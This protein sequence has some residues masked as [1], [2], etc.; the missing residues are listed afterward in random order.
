MNTEWNGIPQVFFFFL[1]FFPLPQKQH[2][3]ATVFS[4]CVGDNIVV[5]YLFNL[6][7][8]CKI[9]VEGYSIWKFLCVAYL[10]ILSWQKQTISGPNK[11]FFLSHCLASSGY[12]VYVMN[13]IFNTSTPYFLPLKSCHA[14]LWLVLAGIMI[15]GN[16]GFRLK[17]KN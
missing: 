14:H 11:S 6:V 9:T 5:V 8:N 1:S 17:Q 15:H 13:F 12:I 2:L 4:L 3:L 10:V 7:V 16:N